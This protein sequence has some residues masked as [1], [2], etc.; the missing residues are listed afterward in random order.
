MN[1]VQSRTE[2]MGQKSLQYLDRPEWA[3]LLAADVLLQGRRNKL[4]LKLIRIDAIE[5]IQEL[6]NTGPAAQKR[7][8][9]QEMA[10][11]AFPLIGKLVLWAIDTNNATLRNEVD[12]VLT[13][14]TKAKDTDALNR[15]QTIYNRANALVTSPPPAPPVFA[16]YGITAMLVGTLNTAILA[17]AGSL[18]SVG[19]AKAITEA[20]TTDLDTAFEELTDVLKE[21][22]LAMGTYRFGAQRTFWEGWQ[23]ARKRDDTGVRH[24]AAR[25]YLVDELTLAKIGQGTVA[26][27]AKNLEK[28]VTKFSLATFMDA[29][30]G[31]GAFDFLAKADLYQ[32]QAIPN[33]VIEDGKVTRLIVKMKKII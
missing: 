5:F 4:E 8:Y 14:L 1:D 16:D 32:D 29:E 11:A 10:E 33:L 17:F 6:D 28:D 9:K 20:A 31:I 15:C 12:F 7:D 22:D 23:I 27:P 30:T 18:G 26:L 2:Q 3:A 13:D 19:A 25:I 24:Q 21:C